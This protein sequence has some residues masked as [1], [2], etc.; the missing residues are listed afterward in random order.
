MSAETTMKRK[1]LLS[2]AVLLAGIG[3]ASAQGMR[4][5]TGGVAGGSEHGSIGAG[6]GGG[7]HETTPSARG[8]HAAEATGRG[9]AKSAVKG[10]ERQ[11]RGYMERGRTGQRETTGQAPRRAETSAGKA[12][13]K[14]A[15]PSEAAHKSTGTT[16]QGEPQHPVLSARPNTKANQAQARQKAAPSKT[17]QGQIQQQPAQKTAPSAARQAPSTTGQAPSATTRQPS[18]QTNTS[19]PSLSRPLATAAGKTMT[20]RQQTTLQRSVLSAANVPRVTNPGF[21][22]N[23]GVFVPG[24]VGVIGV[25]AFPDLVEF[26]PDYRDDSFF[27][28]EDEIVFIGPDRRIVDIVPI[29]PR[30]HFARADSSSITVELTPEEIR[31]VQQVLVDEGFDVSVD[32]VFGA[33]TRQALIGFQRKRG[34]AASGAVDVQTVSALG[35]TGKISQ[36]HIQ[37]G[38]AATTGQGNARQQSAQQPARSNAGAQGNQPSAHP[39]Q[40][41]GQGGPQQPHALQQPRGTTGQGGQQP[42]AQQ[43]QA[44][45]PKGRQQPSAQQQRS[46]S[47]QGGGQQQPNANQSNQQPAQNV[48]PNKG[49]GAANSTSGQGNAQ[50]RKQAPRDKNKP[51]P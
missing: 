12:R 34:L 49:N 42:S 28:V 51:Y 37:G 2:T 6:K 23:T 27:V 7:R 25:S 17:R 31:T 16:G 44:P 33:R 19:T 9:E 13:S 24:T 8:G 18:V 35:L 11:S 14:A 29:G 10:A 48:Q 20:A 4:E 3:F 30:A 5:G 46:T 39:P 45:A 40:T 15:H 41:T 22:I 50:Q 26:F 36:N 1:L 32:G 47:G 43:Q 38:G 21:A